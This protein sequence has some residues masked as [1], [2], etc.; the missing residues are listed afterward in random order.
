MLGWVPMSGKCRDAQLP[1]SR[2]SCCPW[3]VSLAKLTEMHP[4]VAMGVPWTPASERW[5]RGFW[6]YLY[7]SLPDVGAVETF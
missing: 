5:A 6:S 2:H 7:H 3:L 4:E 1:C